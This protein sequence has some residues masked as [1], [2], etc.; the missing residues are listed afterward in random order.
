MGVSVKGKWRR[1]VKGGLWVNSNNVDLSHK[2]HQIFRILS[3]SYCKCK[4]YQTP[5][6]AGSSPVRAMCRFEYLTLNL[7]KIHLLLQNMPQQGHFYTFSKFLEIPKSFFFQ[8]SQISQNLPIFR[9]SKTALKILSFPKIRVLS[10]KRPSPSP[11]RT[12]RTSQTRAHYCNKA[13]THPEAPLTA[14]CSPFAAACTSD[15]CTAPW[16]SSASA[17]PASCSGDTAS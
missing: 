8:N 14:P 5:T 10:S 2:S 17:R 15:A 1:G 3:I 6:Q 16:R 12:N 7:A 13:P 9:N 11:F 4:V